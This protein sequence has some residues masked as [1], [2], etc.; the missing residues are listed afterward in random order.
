MLR[1][2]CPG[3]ARRR[4]GIALTAAV[5]F[6]GTGLAWAAQP[7][8]SQSE[9]LHVGSVQVATSAD[10]LSKLVNGDVVYSG[11]VLFTVADPSTLQL[12]F[13]SENANELEDGSLALS[14]SVRISF[15]SY[16]VTTE[17][18]VLRKDGSIKMDSA[19]LSVDPSA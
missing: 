2:S 4:V 10:H 18:A 5:I 16:V 12:Q 6:A 19:R 3:S 13:S 14:G 8:S 9:E 1:H 7:E 11:N 17:H 15:G